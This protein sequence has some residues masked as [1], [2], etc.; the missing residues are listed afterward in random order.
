MSRS[1]FEPIWTVTPVWLPV[2]AVP[3]SSTLEKEW[4]VT[5]LCLPVGLCVCVWKRDTQAEAG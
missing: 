1:G 4:K 5:Q 2:W 3:A